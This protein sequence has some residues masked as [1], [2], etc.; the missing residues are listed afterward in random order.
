MNGEQFLRNGRTPLHFA[1]RKNAV[2][3]SPAVEVAKV[4]LKQR[5]DIKIDA[6]DNC[7]ETPLYCA[8]RD[9]EVEMVELLLK[10]GA[11][12][13]VKQ[14]SGHTPLRVAIRNNAVEAADLLRRYG[15][16]E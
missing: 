16:H 10:H 6:K 9:N 14:N 11:D 15:G 5:P 2:R 12:V 3:N 4:L 13:N 1:A 7:G 8:A